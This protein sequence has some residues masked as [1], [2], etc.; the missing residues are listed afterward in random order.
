MSSYA[1]SARQQLEVVAGTERRL[2]EFEEHLAQVREH[3]Q[4]VVGN[5]G[6]Q[7][8]ERDDRLGVRNRREKRF[9]ELRVGVQTR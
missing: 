3:D 5:R 6:A 7:Q 2:G 9:D 1:A 4:V 8:R